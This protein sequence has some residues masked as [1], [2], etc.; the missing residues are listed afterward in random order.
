[1][2]KNIRAEGL[3]EMETEKIIVDNT[4]RFNSA[5]W[6]QKIAEELKGKYQMYPATK[7]KML[8]ELSRICDDYSDDKI[9]LDVILDYLFAV[10]IYDAQPKVDLEK[11]DRM[12]QQF[13]GKSRQHILVSMLRDLKLAMSRSEGKVTLKTHLPHEIFAAYYLP[14]TLLKRRNLL[15]KE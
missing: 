7:E 14:G 11:T 5:N 12:S 2:Q 4:K 1:M 6:N 10:C 3:N 9:S 13:L 8:I 15:L